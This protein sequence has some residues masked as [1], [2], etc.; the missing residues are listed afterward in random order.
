MLLARRIDQLIRVPFGCPDDQTSTKPSGSDSQPSMN[1]EL[2]TTTLTPAQVPIRLETEVINGFRGH[3]ESD[4]KPKKALNRA[5]QLAHAR[6]V[7]YFADRNN[8]HVLT[9]LVRR[10][11]IPLALRSLSYNRYC[12][13]FYSDS[14]FRLMLKCA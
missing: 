12:K 1:F 2:S 3:R 4:Y 8:K 9:L 6:R 5:G 13:K 14:G 11:D 10:K 7:N